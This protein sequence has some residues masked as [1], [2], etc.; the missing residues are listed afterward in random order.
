MSKRGRRPPRP[1]KNIRDARKRREKALEEQGQP[2]TEEQDQDAAEAYQ[3]ATEAY[4]LATETH[5]RATETHQ[6][7]TEAYQLATETHQRAIE[8]HQHAVEAYRL[9]VEAQD[10]YEFGATQ[11]QTPAGTQAGH[12]RAASPNITELNEAPLQQTAS[13][14][15]GGSSKT[16]TPSATFLKSKVNEDNE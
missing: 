3:R 9:A 14:E 7:A 4:Q 8:A 11:N 5:L 1:G 6:R 13:E 2:A 10:A 16:I 12:A 15:R